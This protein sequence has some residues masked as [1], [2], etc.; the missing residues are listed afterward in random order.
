[1]VQTISAQL[2]ARGHRF[3]MIV[4]RWNEFIT[5]RLASGAID[6]LVRHGADEGALAQVW[7]PG[8]WEIPLVARRLADSRQY[9]AVICLGCVIRGQTP[10]FEYVAAE[11][12][13]G[14][15]HASMDSGVP[16]LFGVI[17]ADSLEQAIDR[18]GTKAGNKGAEAALAA[19][20]MANLLPQLDKGK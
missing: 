11:V 4:S 1:M 17:T 7:V 10:H 13:K 20:E 8:S 18:A 5:S 12:A 19:I 14:I 6:A 2:D 16:I 3:A 15:A 9:A